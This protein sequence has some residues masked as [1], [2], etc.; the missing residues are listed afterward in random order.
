M[1]KRLGM[2]LGIVGSAL[3]LGA[4][5]I[6]WAC[7]SEANTDTPDGTVEASVSVPAEPVGTADA[8]ASVMP[9][10]HQTPLTQANDPFQR[11]Q[12]SRLTT[13][14]EPARW[15]ESREVKP[16]NGLR[17]QLPDHSEK[18]LQEEP[19]EGPSFEQG[20]NSG[21]NPFSQRDPFAGRRSLAEIRSDDTGA[22]ST[23]AAEVP[24]EERTWPPKDSAAS[25]SNAAPAG[26]STAADV[27]AAPQPSTIKAP[28]QFARPS[29]PMHGDGTAEPTPADT[30]EKPTDQQQPG[31]AI[32]PTGRLRSRLNQNI[33]VTQREPASFTADVTGSP[34]LR[35]LPAHG[36][37]QLHNNAA[38]SSMEGTGRPG[39]KQL[40]GVQ[41]PQVTIQK[42]A[43][44]EV[45][46][47]KAAVIEIKVRNT[48]AVTAHSV[49]V[50]DEV[51]AGTRLVSTTPQATDAPGGKVVWPLGDLAPG[52]EMSVKLELMP[53]D[54]GEIGSVASVVFRADASMR[55]VAT[56]PQLALKV[57][58]PSQVMKGQNLT[59]KITIS[60]PGT[61]AATGVVIEE[62]VPTGLTHPAGS[63]LEFEVG[64]LKPGESRQLELTLTAAAAGQIVNHLIARGDANL[65]AEERLELDVVAPELEVA[66]TGPAKRYLER[67]A[68]YTVSVTN[69][70]TAPAKDVEL[71]THLPKGLKFVK[72]NNA[73]HYDPQ[74][75]SVTWSLEELPPAETGSVLL[76]A[77][78]IE[79]GEQKLLTEGKAQQGLADQHEQTIVVEGLAAI[80]FEVV[81]VED[82][83][84]A[85]GET[86][87]EIRVMNQGSKACTQVQV[88]A[89]LPAEMAP[90]DA[91][92]PVRHQVRGQ[93]IV[94]EP[95][96]RLAPKA[97]TTFRLRV[98]GVQPGHHRVSVQVSCAEIPEPVTKEEST[99]VYSDQ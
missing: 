8:A 82:P 93:E 4:S 63:E 96:P 52:A 60:N 81:D 18:P 3:S 98:Q 47:G 34:G 99:R 23:V 35:Q 66:V 79:A 71:V 43:P 2:Q 32:P 59:V 24:A 25:G 73:G 68:T 13:E 44:A 61:G 58:G 62:H 55:T 6:W 87:Y 29:E 65:Q 85:G 77:L 21:Q 38:P 89:A 84:E 28:F 14:R 11:A 27:D 88:A 78:P 46:V 83:V 40:E 50:H 94:F 31:S 70:G 22:A 7:T 20:N 33:P 16:I 57:E 36:S 37:G 97:D 39:S 86:T 67:Q 51:P 95:L 48:G 15:D 56:R 76:T 54:E 69:P 75:H 30:T 53:L 1:D 74:R 19:G 12:F 49:E 91:E 45:Q 9:V 80:F 90:I 5:L 41:T 72:A 42:V 92:G 10:E 64:E 26:E 17:S